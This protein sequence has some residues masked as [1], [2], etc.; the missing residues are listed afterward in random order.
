MW[1][2]K[3]VLQA[4]GRGRRGRTDL[5][6]GSFELDIQLRHGFMDGLEGLNYIAEDNW[7]PLESFALGETLGIN[8][9]HLLQNG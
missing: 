6:F 8:E 5:V 1:I 3:G 2:L 4:A 7:L 9:L